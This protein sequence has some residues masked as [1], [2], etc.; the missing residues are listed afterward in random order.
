MALAEALDHPAL[1][2]R[3][4]RPPWRRALPGPRP[5]PATG[6]SCSLLQ[7]TDDSGRVVDITLPQA[8]TWGR[9]AA[10]ALAPPPRR[11]LALPCLPPY[12]ATCTLLVSSTDQQ[13]VS[14]NHPTPLTT[15]ALRA[16]PLPRPVFQTHDDA[17]IT[18]RACPGIFSLASA[19]DSN[20]LGPSTVSPHQHHP[21]RSQLLLGLRPPADE[22]PSAARS[23]SATSA[24]CR[25]SSTPPLRAAERDLETIRRVRPDSR[26]GV[27]HPRPA[28][29]I[30]A[31]L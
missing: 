5:R 14:S 21:L 24:S 29:T 12:I 22:H 6:I 17:R 31:I 1:A 8:R 15:C 10:R 16:D 9:Y 18:T 7:Q 4:W 28:S 23:T 30:I 19:I 27:K 3:P 25:P 13:S 20:V 11:A 26:R 2:D